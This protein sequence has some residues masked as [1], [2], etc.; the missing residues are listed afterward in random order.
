MSAGKAPT[1]DQAILRP[2]QHI[3]SALTFYAESAATIAFGFAW[4]VRG[5]STWAGST[6][7]NR[8]F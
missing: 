4:I 8:N 3:L 5:V 2:L 1:A 6:T 7:K